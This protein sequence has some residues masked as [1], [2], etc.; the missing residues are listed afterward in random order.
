MK[1]AGFYTISAGVILVV[2]GAAKIVSGLGK[3]R[4]LDLADPLLFLPVRHVLLIVGVLEL[5]IGAFLL[6]TSDPWSK[7][8]VVGW[9]ATN[10]LLYRLGLLWVGAYKPCNCLGTVADALPL[11]RVAVLWA[12]NAAFLYLLLGSYFL[13]FFA[14]LRRARRESVI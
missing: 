6:L 13:L 12:T 9:L 1:T 11:P 5:L 3:A 8:P 14:W 4:V 7:L 2:T 10:F